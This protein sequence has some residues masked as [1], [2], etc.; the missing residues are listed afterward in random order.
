MSDSNIELV[1]ERVNCF[2]I[3]IKLLKTWTLEIENTQFPV[4]VLKYCSGT[5]PRGKSRCDRANGGQNLPPPPGWNRV[6]V[7]EN[8]GY[9][10]DVS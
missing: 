9:I 8:C 4:L 2:T 3:Y 5:Q 10:P 1:D 6:K 7:S